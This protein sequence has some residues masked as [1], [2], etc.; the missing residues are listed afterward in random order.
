MQ[1]KFEIF[2][3]TGEV[4][5]YYAED[6]VGSYLDE[7]VIQLE[8]EGLGDV[9]VVTGMSVDDLHPEF[10]EQLTPD[11]MVGSVDLALAFTP[12]SDT[13]VEFFTNGVRNREGG[14]HADEMWRA[15]AKALLEHGNTKT[16][17][18]PT[19]LREGV[20]GIL[21]FK[22]AKPQ[23][24]GQTKDKLSDVRVSK[25]AYRLFL[26]IFTTFFNKNKSLAKLLLNRASSLRALK[27]EESAK[28]K[29]LLGVKLSTKESSKGVLPGKLAG[30]DRKTKPMERELYLVEGDSAGGSAKQARFKEYQAVLPL[31]GKPLN[32]YKHPDSKVLGSVEIANILTSIGY[33]PS[34][35]DP[36]G[37]LNYG[38]VILLSD[39]DVDGYHIN[40]LECALFNLYLPEMFDRGMIYALDS[41]GCKF[42]CRGKKTDY[43]FGSSV[44][45]VVKKVKAAKDTIFGKVSYLKGWGELDPPGLREAAMNP[46]TRTLIKLKRNKSEMARFEMIMGEDVQFRKDL[47]GVI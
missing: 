22:I 6:G 19:D 24:S 18:T 45:D 1:P 34:L 31:K 15:Y 38:K 10:A 26:Q 37:S 8:T 47:L 39:S 32:A 42:Y 7:R 35:K 46:E 11:E 12:I 41:S 25:P 44:D 3:D 43:Y 28:R 17:C 16:S 23:F 40:S 36:I 2:V 14:K 13:H 20:V 21:N 30:C 33:N 27:D 4:E 5:T 29:S 9:C